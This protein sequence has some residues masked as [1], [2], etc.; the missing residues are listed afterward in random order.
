MPPRNSPST[1]TPSMNTVTH[2]RTGNASAARLAVCGSAFSSYGVRCSGSRFKR[3]ACN[4]RDRVAR[5]LRRGI[6]RRRHRRRRRT[7][8]VWPVVRCT[9]PARD[10]RTVLYITGALAGAAALVGFY[11][12][13][14]VRCCSPRSWPCRCRH[15]LAIGPYQ[16]IL[17]ETMPRSASALPRVGWRQC[18]APET[19]RRGSATLLEHVPRGAVIGVALLGRL[20]FTVRASTR[21]LL[22]ALQSETKMRMT[23]NACGSLHFAR[24]H[25]RGLLHA[26]RVFFLLCPRRAR[27]KHSPNRCDDGRGIGILLFTIAVLSAL[28]SR[29]NLRIVWTSVSS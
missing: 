22:Q 24:I 26:A 17:P 19:R 11:T 7:A 9:A 25:V 1:P 23:R 3:A 14:H 29:Q 18:R 8:F 16:A 10:T 4:W 21:Y 2:S 28:C 27:S 12:A 15:Q 5:A 6:D 20:Q 13:P